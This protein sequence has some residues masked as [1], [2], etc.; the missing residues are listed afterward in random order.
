[1][2]ISQLQEANILVHSIGICKTKI[3]LPSVE[4]VGKVVVIGLLAIKICI[5]YIK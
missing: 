3:D 1:M 2:L 4:L 5:S